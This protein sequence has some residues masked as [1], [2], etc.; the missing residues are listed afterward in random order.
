MADLNDSGPKKASCKPTS[1]RSRPLVRIGEAVKNVRQVDL[2]DSREKVEAAHR[3]WESCRKGWERHREA[4]TLRGK[5]W[6]SQKKGDVS[7][8]EEKLAASSW[9]W[10][11]YDL[12]RCDKYELKHDYYSTVVLDFSSE[13]GRTKALEWFKRNYQWQQKL[14]VLHKERYREW[15]TT[16]DELKDKDPSWLRR[17]VLQTRLTSLQRWL[18]NVGEPWQ[19]VELEFRGEQLLGADGVAKRQPARSERLSLWWD[20]LLKHPTPRL[21]K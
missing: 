19:V 14:D 17:S 7:E 2:E 1:P 4:W 13:E 21:V 12:T 20:N 18:T 5:L 3:G 16:Y 6:E 15:Q 8:L 11:P 10:F 9:F